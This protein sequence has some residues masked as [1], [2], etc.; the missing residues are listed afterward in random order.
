MRNIL[1]MHV[2]GEDFY[3]RVAE[4]E[5]LW[6]LLD[7]DNVLLLA[8]R[9]V[10]KT[11]VLFRLR[12]QAPNRSRSAVYVSSAG[13]LTELEFVDTLFRAVNTLD[14]GRR[15]VSALAEGPVGRFF[16]RLDG[17][18][19][20]GFHLHLRAAEPPDWREVGNAFA[21]VA[22]ASDDGWILL[23]DEL[24]ILV[25]ALLRQD[26]TTERARTFLEWFRA[27]RERAPRLRWVLAGSVGL[28]AIVA[29]IR[30]SS[31]VQDLAPFT[32]G[33]LHEQ[34]AEGLVETLAASHGISIERDVIEYLL[35]RL[36]WLI[37][38]H[39]QL[40][41]SEI[42]AA[43]RNGAPPVTRDHVDKALALL[44]SPGK[45]IY[46][47][48]WRQRLREELGPPEDT[49]A[50]ALLDAAAQDPNGATAQTLRGIL[51]RHVTHKSARDE[52]LS[53]LLRVLQNDGY[54][55]E[56]RGRF[57]FRSPLVRAFWRSRSTP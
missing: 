23:V 1:G 6:K 41:F 10:G 33:P 31:T 57:R 56:D 25:M 28:D 52:V 37:P 21:D 4:L 29:R 20:S 17:A 2:Q 44:L 30:L 51:A 43:H 26:T 9:R 55:V 38:Y 3:D 39:I 14:T 35:Q 36:G 22:N 53:H 50:M 47:E 15:L 11:S 13:L 40:A 16:G 46:F 48:P 54:L 45:R 27:L 19:A 18:G 34:D 12:E 24:P 7:H 8:P 42:H 49:Q 5:Q 32:L